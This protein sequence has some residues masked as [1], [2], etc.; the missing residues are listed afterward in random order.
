LVTRRAT[1]ELKINSMFSSLLSARWAL[2]ALLG[3]LP[4]RPLKSA[5]KWGA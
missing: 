1:R 4:K 2:N 3:T 5:L